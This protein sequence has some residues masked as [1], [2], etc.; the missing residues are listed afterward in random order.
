VL[1]WAAQNYVRITLLGYKETGRGTKFKEIAINRSWDKFD[2]STWLTVLDEL[3]KKGELGRISIDTT[4]AHRYLDRLKTLGIPDWMYH[5][6]EGKYSV[7][8]DMVQ[9]TIGPSS[10]HL[11]KLDPFNVYT[12][13]L[14]ARFQ[15]IEP[16]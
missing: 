10:Y 2:E 9:H 4:L 3:H 16:V 14:G 5:V 7:Y 6:E 13:D 11:D 8:L 12:D 15:A 1:K